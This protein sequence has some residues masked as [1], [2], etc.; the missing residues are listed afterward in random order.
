MFRGPWFTIKNYSVITDRES[1]IEVRNT[2][3]WNHGNEHMGQEA[4][5]QSLITDT[6]LTQEIGAIIVYITN[7]VIVRAFLII[8]ESISRLTFYKCAWIENEYSDMITQLDDKFLLFPRIIS[9]FQFRGSLIN[10]FEINRLK[11]FVKD[12]NLENSASKVCH[13]HIDVY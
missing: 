1:G 5:D 6:L 7:N 3:R 8:D 13:M 9:I 11:K 12:I 10:T 4:G 2:Y